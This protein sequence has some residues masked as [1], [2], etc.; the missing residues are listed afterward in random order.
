MREGFPNDE[1]CSHEIPKYTCPEC[2]K[3]GYASK[4]AVRDQGGDA[5]RTPHVPTQERGRGGGEKA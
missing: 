2:G 1:M 5:M 3:I 4:E